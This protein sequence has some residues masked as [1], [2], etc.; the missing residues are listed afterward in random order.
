MW[1]ELMTLLIVENIETYYG[2]IRA[3]D[4]VSLNVESGEIVCL[5]GANG[6]G[7]T[8]TLKT[9]CGLQKPSAGKILF[10]GEDLTKV[11]P[12]EI[13]TR[14]IA[15]V[16]EGRHVFSR[17]SVKENLAMGAFSRGDQKSIR[18][19]FEKMFILFPRLRERSRQLAGTLSG[20]EQQMLAI[21]RALMAHPR[22]LL[23]DEP[24]MGLSP[25]LLESIF[26]IIREINK[27]G[28]S[29]LLV[30]QNALMA[31]SIAN[32]GYVL[33]TGKVVLSGA[34]SEL[35]HN[36]M[37]INAYLGGEAVV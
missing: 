22:L 5:I 9:I 11:P 1:M 25:I 16:P 36:P 18:E 37:V 34:A 33:D 2:K 13:V 21:A 10:S 27:N 3:I 29:I 23:L 26:G 6:A 7:K 4:G 17:L 28:T 14:G 31:L 19:D 32:R 35:V 24:S 8:T 12:H 15:L 30:E 20:G